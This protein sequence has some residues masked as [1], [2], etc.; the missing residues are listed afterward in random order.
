VYGE[1][2]RATFLCTLRSPPQLE[3][4]AWPQIETT[5]IREQSNL[6]FFLE[7]Q[8]YQISNSNNSEP[9]FNLRLA[10]PK[11]EP[12]CACSCLM[13]IAQCHIKVQSDFKVQN[14]I[15]NSISNFNWQ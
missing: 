13:L 8:Q 10:K 15:S 7:R 11:P 14:A 1:R 12:T 9:E 2:A 6:E 4:L 3:G 5:E